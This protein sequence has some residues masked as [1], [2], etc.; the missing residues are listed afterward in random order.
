MYIMYNK[1]KK[2]KKMNTLTL[3]DIPEQAKQQAIKKGIENYEN[4]K[5][6]LYGIKDIKVGFIEIFIGT[7]DGAMI[8]NLQSAVKNTQT[9]IGQFPK[10]F[11]LW[12]IGTIDEQ[13]GKGSGEPKFII[14]AG[15]LV[16]A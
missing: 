11:E 9:Q 1:Q 6:N 5:L 14:S 3:K 4:K 16:E 12:K 7:T 8:R 13:T 15:D 2:G 10:D